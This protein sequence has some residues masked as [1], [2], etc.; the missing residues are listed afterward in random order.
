MGKTSFTSCPSESNWFSHFGL[1]AESRIGFASEA[2]K[3]LHIKI[4][5]KVLNMIKAEADRQPSIVA[6]EL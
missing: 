2:N 6:N 3:P 1:G 4:V 5:V